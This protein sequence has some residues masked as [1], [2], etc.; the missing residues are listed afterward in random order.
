MIVAGEIGPESLVW[1]GAQTTGW[2]LR[3]GGVIYDTS[4]GLLV[5]LDAVG[6][7]IWG[8]LDG[9]RTVGD[10]ASTLTGNSGP[11]PQGLIE[12]VVSFLRALDQAGVL[13]GT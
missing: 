3:D 12:A 6:A 8:R 4:R 13:T 1:R 7:D 2:M 9:D 11:D 5:R 10:I